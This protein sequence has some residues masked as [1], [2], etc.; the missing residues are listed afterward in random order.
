METINKERLNEFFNNEEK[1][2]E[3]LAELKWGNGF[4]CRKC[5]H[6][7]SCQGKV[8]FSRRCTRCK[9]EESATA[10]TVFHNLK[11]PVNKAFYILNRIY[12]NQ[13]PYSAVELARDLELRQTSVLKI[14]IKFENRLAKMKLLNNG[15]KPS[16]ED[17]IVGNASLY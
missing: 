9:N 15:N 4:V 11:F 7:N 12:S 8:P 5:Q 2:L 10:A 1:S 6:I 3:F 13:V 17:F 16:F 14:I